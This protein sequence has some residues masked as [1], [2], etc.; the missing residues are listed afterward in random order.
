ML[1]LVLW[2]SILPSVG[3]FARCGVSGRFAVFVRCACVL[4]VVGGN[5][6]IDGFRYC[7]ICAYGRERCVDG[8]VRKE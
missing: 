7:V 2:R 1:G 5:G 6:R 4:C 8:L 3:F